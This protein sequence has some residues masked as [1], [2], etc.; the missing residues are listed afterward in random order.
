MEPM[1]AQW[2]SEDRPVSGPRA[3]HGGF[4]TSRAAVPDEPTWL[5]DEPVGQTE[6]PPSWHPAAESVEPPDSTGHSA[7]ADEHSSGRGSS[8]DV[9]AADSATDNIWRGDGAEPT[10]VGDSV[11]DAAASLPASDKASLEVLAQAVAELRTA[12][13]ASRR[14][15]EHQR[16]LLDKLH[17]DRQALREAEHRR[18][19]DPVVRELIQLSDTCLRTGRQWKARTDVHEETA[20]RVHAV[21]LDAADDVRLIL[22]RQGVERFAVEAGE[23]FD[24]SVAKAVS[25]KPTTNPE[26]DGIVAEVQKL[27]Y[28]QDDRVIRFS[29]VLVW[30]FVP[31]KPADDA[32]PA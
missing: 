7:P 3:D 10:V 15:E 24:R 1:A 31:A 27:G 6:P 14:T 5:P 22:E 8:S 25:S 17:D 23:K 2:N 20:E 26:L 19:R 9:N 32:V 4:G 12:L 16:E 21:L 29:E 28:R 11:Q 18:S 30:K 13:E